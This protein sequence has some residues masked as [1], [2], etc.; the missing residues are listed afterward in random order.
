MSTKLL[1]LQ[2]VE[3]MNDLQDF[4]LNYAQ[5]NQI[6]TISLQRILAVLY[7]TLA[8]RNRSTVDVVVEQITWEFNYGADAYAKLSTPPIPPAKPVTP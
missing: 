1:T 8:I 5:R 7:C 4:L 3:H 6:G 2:E